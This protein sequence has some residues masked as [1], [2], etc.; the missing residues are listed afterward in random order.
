MKHLNNIVVEN[1][2]EAHGKEMIEIFKKLEVDTRGLKGSCTKE[3]GD[4]GIYY[5][6]I[7]YYFS[8]YSLKEVQQSNA[9]IITLEELKSYL[10]PEIKQGDKVWVSDVSEEDAIKQKREC[11]FICDKRNFINYEGLY[12]YLVIDKDDNMWNFRYIVK[13]TEPTLLEIAEK[14][15]V[16]EDYIKSLV[17]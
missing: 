5:G 4:D 8:N 12:P 1:L 6:L 10:E 17:K 16:T 7:N 15:G 3:R 9:K 14:A 13:V 2:D 11:I